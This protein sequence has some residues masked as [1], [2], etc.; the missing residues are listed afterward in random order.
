MPD[1]FARMVMDADRRRA[2]LHP[3]A[4]TQCRSQRVPPKTQP[5]S[6]SARTNRASRGANRQSRWLDAVLT[7]FAMRSRV[8]AIG[9][10]SA[11]ARWSGTQ[12]RAA[13][14]AASGQ[15]R[16]HLVTPSSSRSAQSAAWGRT[17][18]VPDFLA[19][20]WCLERAATRRVGIG[21]AFVFGLLMDVHDAH[22]SA[23]HAL[24]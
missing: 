13:P 8:V 5:T 11:S 19:W 2:K 12:L 3:S 4:D 18:L 1:Q 23:T 22:C 21:A 6:A 17:P 24:A 14:S 7:S 20:R 10:L 15:S 9:G 16:L